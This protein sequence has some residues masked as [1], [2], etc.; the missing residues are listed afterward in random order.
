MR[1]S[2]MINGC[3]ACVPG[4]YGCFA[5]AALLLTA[6][7]SAAAAAAACAAGGRKMTYAFFQS[8]SR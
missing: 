6:G 1:H 2:W 7:P 5:G 3:V 4:S 8:E